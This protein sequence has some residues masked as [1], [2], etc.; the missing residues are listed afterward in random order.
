[1]RKTTKSFS[2]YSGVT[3]GIRMDHFPNRSNERNF[4]CIRGS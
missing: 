2:Q 3:A 1:M 4:R